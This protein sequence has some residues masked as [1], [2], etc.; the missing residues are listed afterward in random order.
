MNKDFHTYAVSDLHGCLHM[1]KR[2]K[3]FLQPDDRV[4]CLGDCGDRGPHC[5]ETLK[6]ILN[7]PQFTLLKGN[8]E[9]MLVQALEDYFDHPGYQYDDAFWLLCHNG[10]RN[11]FMEFLNDNSEAE[12]KRICKQIKN[13]PDRMTYYNKQGQEVILTHSG[14]TPRVGEIP[15]DTIWDRSHFTTKWPKD[16]EFENTILV[17]G[18]TPIDLQIEEYMPKKQRTKWEF[19][20]YWYCDNHKVNIDCGTVWVDHTVLLDL[21]TWDEQIFLGPKCEVTTEVTNGEN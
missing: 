5:W 20:A 11:T 9:D 21:D 16:K 12:Q 15:R 13:L 7:D 2:I 17:H 10:G 18:H 14:Y 6:A 1:Y 8:H 3:K 19:G 4:Y